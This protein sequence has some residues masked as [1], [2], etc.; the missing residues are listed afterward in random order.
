MRFKIWHFDDI[1]IHILIF[2]L[3]SFS[4]SSYYDNLIWIEIIN[5]TCIHESKTKNSNQIEI[6]LKTKKKQNYTRNIDK[7]N[8]DGELDNEIE[9]RSFCI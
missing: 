9:F 8:P 4:T 2:F 3:C 1:L 6:G 7:E 5:Q